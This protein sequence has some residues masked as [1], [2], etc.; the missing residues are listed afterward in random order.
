[1]IRREQTS[2]GGGEER[3]IKALYDVSKLRPANDASARK[4]NGKKKKGKRAREKKNGQEYEP[5]KGGSRFHGQKKIS[6]SRKANAPRTKLF[7][8]RSSQGGVRVDF[9]FEKESGVP[10]REKPVS[11]THETG[12]RG[13][14]RGGVHYDKRTLTL[15]RY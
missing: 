14:R 3:T 9:L 11:K 13:G 7:T 6:S 15:V 8:T 12:G 1:M 4:G 5:R 10:A 2:G